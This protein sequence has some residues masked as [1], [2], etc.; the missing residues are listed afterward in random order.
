MLDIITLS[1]GALDSN[2]YI[3]Y[4]SARDAVI[5]DPGDNADMLANKLQALGLD[6]KYIIFT[7]AH[8]DHIGAANELALRYGCPAIIHRDDIAILNDADLNLSARFTGIPLCFNG[9]TITV[10]DEKRMIIGHEFQFIH[11]P[12]HTPGSMCIKVDGVIF[13]GDTLFQ[14]SVG[15]SFPP[16]GNLALEL[17]SIKNNLFSLDGDAVCYPGHGLPTS[18]ESERINNPYLNQGAQWI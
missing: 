4:N 2:C 11:T 9:S 7:H 16:Y 1:V 3:V 5:I 15:N 13:T 6:L 17:T 10:G 14:N 8:F 12:G 18:L